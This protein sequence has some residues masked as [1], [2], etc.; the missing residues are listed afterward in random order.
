[1]TQIV[2]A[3][4]NTG[5]RKELCEM[6]DAHGTHIEILGLD[7]FPTLGPLSETGVTFE[8]NALEK[9]RAVV[10]ATGYIAV[11]DDS[12]LEVDALDGAPGVHSARYSG[13]EADDERNNTK[14]LRE[15]AGIPF[16]QRSA[17]FR[18]VLAVVTPDGKETTVE[19]VWEGYIADSPA[20]SNGFGYDPLFF[21]P[22]CGCTSAELPAA[23]KNRRSHRGKA[24]KA[25]AE[26][27]KQITH[28][29]QPA[30]PS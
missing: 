3:T 22:E 19:G 25:L 4:N 26:K 20:G 5:K 18:C 8:A 17:R 21:D 13:P 15:L 30:A 12:G 29:T 6:L 11:A 27:W 28:G 10:T 23:E 1:M 9:A 24:L 2:L 16:E 14:L 7:A